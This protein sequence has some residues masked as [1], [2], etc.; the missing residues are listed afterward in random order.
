LQQDVEEYPG[1]LEFRVPVEVRNIVC[2]EKTE[3]AEVTWANVGVGVG[4]RIV[5]SRVKMSEYPGQEY[6]GP[7]E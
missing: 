1:S 4:V 3:G 6:H 5:R 7:W 2:T